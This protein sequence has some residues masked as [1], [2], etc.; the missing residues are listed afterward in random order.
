MD[1]RV[2]QAATDA[3]R[4][5]TLSAAGMAMLRRLR[6]HP[7]APR[8]HNRSGNRLL[9]G[10]VEELRRYEC[11][12]A[13]APFAWSPGCPPP[14]L[15]GFLARVFAQVPHYRARGPLPAFEDITPVHR[16]DFAADIAR[17][18]PDDVPLQRMIQFRTTG[19]TGHPLLLPSHPLVA[20]RYLAHHKRALAR[21][22]ITLRHG[23]RQV[24]VILL[25]MQR[26]CFTYVSVTPTMGES[27]LAKINLHPDDWNHPDD[28]ARY[29]AQMQPEVIAGDPISFATLLKLSLDYQP[30]ALLSVSMA[31]STGLRDALAARFGCP[32]LDLYSMNEAGPLAVFDAR[33]NGHV[34]LQPGMYVEILDDDGNVLP[35]GETGEITLTGGF[36]FCLPLLR[37]R[38]G[39][40]GALAMSRDGPMIVGLQGRRPVR[41]LTAGGRWVNNIDLTH[42]LLPLPLS[43]YTV[44]QAADGGV[45]LHL[46][47]AETLHGA[48]AANRL[49]VVLEGRPVGV[50]VL[51]AE[52]KILQYRS[53]LD[54]GL[55]A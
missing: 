36:N 5:P 16:G 31:L 23:R 14:W 19:T 10:E 50:A 13:T 18:V 6:E 30:R 3:E 29:I 20:A 41:F 53:D 21:F 25:G 38:T 51:T 35:A 1:A 45:T 44:H 11:D 52:D 9:A 46:P 47:A 26:H 12:I 33:C 7:A 32:V 24:G 42:A 22:G 17:F 27:G 2:T 28:R 15:P 8:F 4:Y 49:Q 43:R 55:V 48:D 40:H 54:G 34:L 37:Y 39:D